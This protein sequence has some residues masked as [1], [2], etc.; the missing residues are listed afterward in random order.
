MSAKFPGG[1]GSRTF[2]S[3]KSKRFIDFVE[4]RSLP[5]AMS[6]DEYN[7]SVNFCHLLIIFANSG[8]RSG[9]TLCGPDLDPNQTI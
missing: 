8:P 3:S 7:I 9:P 4:W 6:S 1:G 2:F 5:E